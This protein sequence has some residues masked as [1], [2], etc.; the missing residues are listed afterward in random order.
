MQKSRTK[1]MPKNSVKLMPK[2]RTKPMPKN[3]TRHIFL[4]GEKGIGKST[5]WKKIFTETSIE[6]SGFVTGPL[7]IE[8]VRKGAYIHALNSCAPEAPEDN[9]Q[10]IGVRIFSKK[11]VPITET[12]ETFGVEILKKAIVSGNVVFMDELGRLERDAVHFK[13][14]VKECMDSGVQVLGTLQDTPSEF[15]EEIKNREDVEVY[16]VTEA[17]RDIL[18][19]EILQKHFI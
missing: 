6:H 12:F 19:K 16:T 11:I 7:E 8:G 2:N 18:W 5:I 17:N 3:S 1:S 13:E 10:I 14:T 9:N 4:T 15:L